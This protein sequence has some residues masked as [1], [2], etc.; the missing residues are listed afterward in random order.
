MMPQRA[1]TS[2]VA[3][4]VATILLVAFALGGGGS[5]F[6]L[7]NLAVQFTALAA[8][9]AYPRPV[10]QFWQQ[11]PLGIRAVIAATIVLPLVHLIPLP[12]TVWS[13][14]PGRNLVSV[15]LDTA[16]TDGA[17]PISLYPLRTALAASALITPF[18]VLALAWSLPRHHL[19]NLGWMGV[20]M[21]L[22][23]VIIG[24]LQIS[25][26]WSWLEFWPEGL[27]L[28]ALLGTFANRN[29]TAIFLVGALAFAL[30]L[31][32]P[33]PVSRAGLWAARGSSAALLVTAIILTK[34]RT[35]LALAALPIALFIVQSAIQTARLASRRL[36]VS[37][38]IAAAI[39][40]IAGIAAI[41]GVIQTSPGRLAETLERFDQTSNDARQFI[42]EDA[43]YAANRYW[44]VG[45]GMGT[46][47]EV[48]QIDEAVENISVRRAGRAHND[49]IEITLEAGAAGALLV[50]AWLIMIGWLAWRARRSN[51]RWSAWAAGSFLLAIGLQSITDYPLRNQTILAMAA[52]A[53]VMLART[54]A[55]KPERSA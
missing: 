4:A 48:F 41:A 40:A 12:E 30:F 44:P 3:F 51:D 50:S 47:D 5:R 54:G 39:L 13:N 42:W 23:S 16:K 25:T 32:L 9:A 27:S 21:G 31:P 22:V 26:D 38:A 43:I 29:T 20:A 37:P 7:A 36:P 45:S 15:T 18:A 55:G 49:Y 19:F 28:N 14:L 8:L 46:F 10:W 17:M 2:S 24:A 6:G 35:G 33:L 34:S 1:A 53:F 52:V 11:A